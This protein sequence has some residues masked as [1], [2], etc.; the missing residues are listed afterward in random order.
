MAPSYIVDVAGHQ[1]V[2]EEGFVQ[3]AAGRTCEGCSRKSV[4]VGDTLA[5]QYFISRDPRMACRR[6]YHECA[7]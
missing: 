4:R 2:M 7:I 1:L 5:G 6:V 3:M